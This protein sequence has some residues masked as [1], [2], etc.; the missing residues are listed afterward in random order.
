MQAILFPSSSYDIQ[1]VDPS[2]EREYDAVSE[3][4]LFDIVLFDC[5][6]WYDE[7]ELI[8]NKTVSPCNAIYRGWMMKPSQYI[9]FYSKL[10]EQNITLC[11]TPE[12][13]EH[14]HIFPNVYPEF[15]D[16]TAKMLVFPDRKV[17]FDLVKNTFKKFIVKDYVKSVKGTDFPKYFT[18]SELSEN[19]FNE[20]INVFLKYRG[21]RLTGGI[22]IKEFLDLKKYDDCCNEFRIFVANNNVVSISRNSGQEA[23]TPEPPLEFYQKYTSM[24]SHFYT[25]DVSEIQDGSWKVIEAGDGSVSGLSDWQDYGAFFRS[26]YYAFK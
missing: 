22:C 4:K 17:S 20:W 15:G 16:D 10:K 18:S 25:V 3:G 11:T 21:N 26:L 5:D 19:E 12:E 24:K 6:K 13:Y 8:L 2:L 23:I 7:S 1:K 14:F 9:Q